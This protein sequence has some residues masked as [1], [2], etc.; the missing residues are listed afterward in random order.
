MAGVLSGLS[1]DLAAVV[2]QV[3]PAVVQVEGRRRMAAS[4]IVWSADGV[5]VTAHHVLESDEEKRV[6]LP[7]GRSIAASVVGRDPQTDLA[8][9]RADTG[10][11]A[12]PSWRDAAGLHV[13]HIVLALG[14]PGKTVRATLG[15]VSA[16]GGAWISPAGGKIE[17]YLQTDVLMYPGFSGGPLVNASGDVLGLNTSAILRGISI[18]VPTLTVRS[19]VDTILAHGRVQRGYLGVG[20]QP[21]RLPAATAQKQGQETAVLLVSVASGSPADK[22]GLLLGDTVLALG[23]EQVRTLDDLRTRLSATAVGA[24]TQVKVLRG[25]EVRDIGVTIG[26]AP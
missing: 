15:V 19:V 1:E 6:G 22:A 10:G 23:G 18:T 12:A 2:A 20:T 3:E 8:V 11:L 21:V 5:I 7:D 26:E 24:K 13:G 14:R 9:L 4:G 25:G 16:L 17:P